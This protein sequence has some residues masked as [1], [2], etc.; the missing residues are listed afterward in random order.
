MDTVYP[1]M[2]H[3]NPNPKRYDQMAY[4]RCGNSGLKLPLV[5]LE[6]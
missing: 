3:H 5:S 2:E 4:R 6:G 1:T